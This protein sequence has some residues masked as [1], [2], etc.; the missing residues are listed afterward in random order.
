MTETEQ[1]LAKATEQFKAVNTPF[2]IEEC[3]R[4]M[5][6][7]SQMIGGCPLCLAAQE[8]KEGRTRGL[9]RTHEQ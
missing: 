5:Q 6:G 9:P 8:L 7:S 1:R 2:Y 3:S 4:M